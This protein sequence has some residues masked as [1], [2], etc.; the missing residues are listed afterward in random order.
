M[1][2]PR[3]ALF[4]GIPLVGHLHPLI[5]QAGELA[6]RGWDVA[7]ATHDEAVPYVESRSERVR[8][9]PLGPMNVG[10]PTWEEMETRVTLERSFVR[11][12]TDLMLWIIAR[13]TRTFDGTLAAIRTFQPQVVVCD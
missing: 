5:V 13:L 6:A 1:T 2:L 10:S 7:V 11:S 9:I 4:V 8:C 12:S 3:R